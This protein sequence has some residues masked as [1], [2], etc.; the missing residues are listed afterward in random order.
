MRV[1]FW[2]QLVQLGRLCWLIVPHSG[3]MGN[4]CILILL[5]YVHRFCCP[6]TI[7]WRRD[8]RLRWTGWHK[9]AYKKSFQI[10]RFV[11]F[12]RVLMAHAVRTIVH[13]V[14]SCPAL[15]VYCWEPIVRFWYIIVSGHAIRCWPFWTSLAGTIAVE[16]KDLFA[17]FEIT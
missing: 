9:R 2:G 7:K 10:K 13:V 12:M 8:V 14:I 16:E 6:K 15:V 17:T 1:L 3:W 11:H 4:G 5:P